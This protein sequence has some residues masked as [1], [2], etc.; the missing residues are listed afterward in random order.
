MNKKL[1]NNMFTVVATILCSALLVSCG[2]GSCSNGSEGNYNLVVDNT[3]PVPL[4]NSSSQQFYVYMTNVGNGNAHDLSWN[5]VQDSSTNTV[6]SLWGNIKSAVGLGGTSDSTVKVTG[7]EIKIID[8]SNCINVNSGVSCRILLQASDPSSVILQSTSKTSTS[9]ITQNVVSAYG[10]TPSYSAPEGTLTLSPLSPVNYGNGFAG[11]TFFII[12]NSPTEAINLD[13][14]P[15]G[16]L[17]AGINYSILAGQTCPNPLP[18]QS[19]C[20][21]RMTLTSPKGSVGATTPVTL[22]PTGTVVGGNV[23][24][25]Q[26]PVTMTV[27]NEK[28]GNV[29]TST[30]I[31][32][33]D[34]NSTSIATAYAYI[35]N[36]GSGPLSLGSLSSSNSLLNISSDQ[37]SNQTLLPGAVCRYQLNIDPTQIASSGSAAVSIPYN[38]GKNSGTNAT[39]VSWVYSSAVTPAPGI[40]LTS[41]PNLSQINPT[42]TLTI[43]NSGN[44]VLRNLGNLVATPTNPRLSIVSSCGTTLLVGESCNYAL[45][46]APSAP[47]ETETISLGGITANY[48]DSNGVTQQITLPSTTSVNLSSTY[49]G[50]INTETQTVDLN[51]TTPNATIIFKNIGNYKATLSG[52]AANGANLLIAGG[53]CVAGDIA[54]DTECTVVVALQNS[55]AAGSGNGNVT[56]TYNNNNGTSS[57]ASVTN[58]NWL[59]GAAPS[60]SVNFGTSNLV[61]VVGSESTTSVRFLNNG[62]T[63]LSNIT[64]PTPPTGF[65]WQTGAAP[66]CVTNNTQTLNIGDICNLTLKYAPSTS[67]AAGAVTLGSFSATTSQGQPY[68]SSNP[69]TVSATAVS[70]SVLSFSQPTIIQGANWTAPT[71]ISTVVITNTDSSPITITN[72]ATSGGLPISISGCS[73]EIQPGSTCT[74]TVNGG[75][76]TANGSGS[77]IFN[78][79]TPVG[80]KSQALPLSVDYQAQPIITPNF[81]IGASPSGTVD[82]YNNGTPVNITLTLT[83]T[84]TVANAIAPT[85]DGNVQ[86]LA[87][88]LLPTVS[89]FGFVAG[90]GGSCSVDGNG[91]ITI[92]NQ[93]GS[94]NCTYIVTVTATAPAGSPVTALLQSQ[95]RVQS[96]GSSTTPSYGPD[97][98]NVQIPITVQSV[99]PTAA[100]SA[101]ALVT[102]SQANALQVEMGIASPVVS[103]RLVNNGLVPINGAITAPNIPGM[104]FDMSACNNLGAGSSCM[105]TAQIPSTTPS[106]L[107]G[108]LNTQSLLYNNGITVVSANFPSTSIPY[109]VNAPNMPIIATTTSV[110]NCQQGDGSLSSV[111]LI[112]TGN[113]APV[114][115]LTYTNSGSGDAT[116]FN[117]NSTDLATLTSALSTAGVYTLANNCVNANLAKQGGTCTVVISP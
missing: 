29:D 2:S 38:D 10:Y 30:P 97:Q 25:T 1:L 20:Q 79:S 27:T 39:S 94:N 93:A 57:D 107:S 16:T 58:V 50:L 41:G 74:L 64:L 51:A 9:A 104:V 13:Q 106:G 66:S 87:S 12:N 78:Y 54:P 28:L 34:A 42:T 103:F 31:M 26:Q 47:S 77:I 112:N 55:T 88:S 18:A 24:P 33:V 84:T 113:P 80:A 75:P 14:A 81:S 76:Y 32:N 100:L 63:T 99:Q 91:Y 4:I 110:S 117:L 59:I 89:G 115:T 36:T 85:T 40:T 48:I 5:I 98:S 22:T 56:L 11:Y 95:Y 46:Y 111:C 90:T 69:Y 17:P 116:N 8:S 114:V 73:G 19:V 43:I 53:T 92:G 61:A 83:N 7:G 86:V 37:C 3:S 71:A 49:Q 109:S 67:I 101:P 35:S 82:I 23:L 44:V 70:Q 15:F 68:T 60:L 96:Y 6:K 62:N 102:P 65:S 105:F 72:I 108:N 52:I 45:T 21:V